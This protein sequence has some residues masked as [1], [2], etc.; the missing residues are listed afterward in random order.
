MNIGE[1]HEVANSKFDLNK[2]V[3]EFDENI[4]CHSIGFTSDFEPVHQPVTSP[5]TDEEG[6]ILNETGEVE[7]KQF[8]YPLIKHSSCKSNEVI[9]LLHGLNERFWNKYLTWAYCLAIETKKPVILF[10]LAFHMNRSPENWSSIRAMSVIA[11]SRKERHKDLV[12]CSFA[13]VAL[14]LRMEHTPEMFQVSGIQSYFDVIK[15][16]ATIKSGN[17]PYINEN[18]SVS[19][20]AYSIGALLA[21]V[22]LIA[23]PASLFSG[24]KAFLFCGG[25][26]F[27]QINGSSKA[28]MDSLACDK[29]KEYLSTLNHVDTRVKI[30]Q[31]LIPLLPDAW[32]VFKSMSHQGY[33]ADFRNGAFR[34]LNGRVKAI[35]LVNDKVVPAAAIANT[36]PAN[37]V[38]AEDF[39]YPYS[40]EMPFPLQKGNLAPLANE[41]FERVFTVACKHLQ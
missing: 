8:K 10:P 24:E 4:S 40:H 7:N 35:G 26:T 22:L 16:V 1:I 9:I 32:R 2:T 34:E 37:H 5:V 23:N 3:V 14:S 20:F 30:P 19:F 11:N 15:L 17:H 36:L 21:E 13:N 31:N 39:Q 38:I 27:D 12:N 28:I 33:D 25:A 18:A 29:L 41:A 6:Y